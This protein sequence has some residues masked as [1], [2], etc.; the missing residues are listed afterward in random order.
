MAG[1]TAGATA[2][3]PIINEVTMCGFAVD[4]LLHIGFS[5]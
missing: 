1:W 2:L 5:C 4:D 3:Q